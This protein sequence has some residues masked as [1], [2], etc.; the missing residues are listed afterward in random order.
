MEDITA[1]IIDIAKSNFVD[2]L[3]FA[4][5]VPY[6]DHI[7]K[8]GGPI[9]ADYKSAISLAL[10]IPDSIVDFL[11]A[12]NDPNVACV[13]RIHGYEVLNSRLDYIVSLL[14]SFLNQRGFRTLPIPAAERT[15]QENAIPTVSHKMI[16]HIAG[17]GWIGKN[18]LLVT[19]DHGPRMRLVSLLTDAPVKAVD[20]LQ[21]E[22]CGA[23]MACAKACPVGAIKGRAFV[24]DEPREERFDFRKCQRYF[25]ELKRT[26]KHPVCG[27]CLYACPYGNKKQRF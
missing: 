6:Q 23:C 20:N 8:Y 16:A 27:M 2:L 3:G 19:P 12:R 5:L 21:T 17:L 7:V 11:P 25:D 10:R 9:T 13:Y 22:Q 15:D 1:K 18:C 4:D 26:Q 14:S 24:R